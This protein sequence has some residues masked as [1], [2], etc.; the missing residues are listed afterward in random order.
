MIFTD[1]RDAGR[2]LA[3][4]LEEYKNTESVVLAIPRGGV[5]VADEVASFLNLPLSLIIPRKIGA[6]GNPELAIGATAGEGQVVLNN[7]VVRY[8][9][10]SEDYIKNAVKKENEEIKRRQASYL[11]GESQPDLSGKNVIIIDDGIATGST[12]QASIIAVKAKNPKKTILAVPVAPIDAAS[13]FKGLLDDFVVLDTP[14]DFYAVGQFY[15][16]FNQT[17]DG[18]VIEILGKYR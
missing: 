9:N 7:D 17:T 10:I 3:R 2:R 13:K 8:L 6:P 16:N 15:K 12:A 5:V 1:R 11:H 4:A 14:V 18:E